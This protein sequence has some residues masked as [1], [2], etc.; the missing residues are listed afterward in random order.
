[1]KS[2]FEM[3]L[4]DVIVRGRALLHPSGNG[5]LRQQLTTLNRSSTMP[6]R[7]SFASHANKD[8]ELKALISKV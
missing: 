4:N 6:I 1:M 2:I 7:C 8:T 5:R 3:A